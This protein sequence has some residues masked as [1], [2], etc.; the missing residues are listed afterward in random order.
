MDDSKFYLALT[1][2]AAAILLALVALGFVLMRRRP[3]S[4]AQTDAL[5]PQAFLNDVANSTEQSS[6]ELGAT[7]IV[8]GRLQGP[9]NDDVEYIVIGETT[10]GR[11]HALIEYKEHS[12][13]VTDQNS[14]NGT[15]VNNER[16]ETGV[17]LK[18]GDRI[19]FH[20]HEFEFQVLDMFE[21]DRTMMSET[22]F[23]DASPADAEDDA[24]IVRIDDN[25]DVQASGKS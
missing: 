23:A 22:V 4:A 16:L 17:R 14:L 12:F 3:V 18:H 7:P 9:E 10:I 19:R 11:R 2:G 20:K 8:I 1:I 15:F 24:T 13:W 5:M 6:Y 25:G 21:S